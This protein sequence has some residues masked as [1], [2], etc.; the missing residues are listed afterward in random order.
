MMMIFFLTGFTFDDVQIVVIEESYGDQVPLPFDRFSGTFVLDMMR[1]MFYL[2]SLGLGQRQQG[3]SEFIATVS[4]DVPFGLG[5]IPTEA[6]Y[7]YMASIRRE[8]LRARLLHIPFDYPI[9]PYH[10]IMTDYFARASGVPSRLNISP[11]GSKDGGQIEKLFRQLQ[12]AD[13]YASVPTSV[14]VAPPSPD[15]ASMMT[16]YFPEE[17][18]SHESSILFM[19][20]SDGVFL[21]DDYQDEIAMMSLSQ[22]TDTTQPD[23]AVSFDETPVVEVFDVVQTNSTPEMLCVAVALADAFMFEGVVSLMVVV[24]DSVDSPLSFD[25]LS[26]FVSRAGDVLTSSYMDMSFFEYFSVSHVDDVPSFTRCSPTSHVYDIDGEFMQHDLDEDTSSILDHSPTGQRVSPTTGDTEIVDFG[27][28][29][30]PREL[31]FGSDLSVDERERFIQLLGSYL[32]VFEWSYE[33][34]PGLNPSVVQH[35]LP[36]LPHVRLVKQKLRRLHPKWSLKVKEES[37]SSSVWVSYQWLST[38]SGWPMS[39]RFQKKTVR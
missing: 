9:R 11:E 30:Q 23:S 28:T 3:I 5:Y 25:V 22:M 4:H 2:P 37:R 7:R 10:M 38:L 14:L 17:I 15:R 8:R 18:G 26:G 6:D 39:S 13:E 31:K 35:R 36:V 20:M 27:T 12:L 33:D 24:S 1:G 19:G 34:M 29:D 32:D 16:L 21:P